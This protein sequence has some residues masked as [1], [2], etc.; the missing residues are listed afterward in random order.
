MVFLH[1]S[2]PRA[3]DGAG[4]MA[5]SAVFCSARL[6]C[7]TEA[8][9][10]ARVASSILRQVQGPPHHAAAAIS[11]VRASPGSRRNLNDGVYLPIG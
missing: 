5:S 6:H 10:P 2:C 11:Q 4:A 1:S 9:C 8:T 3:N 7:G